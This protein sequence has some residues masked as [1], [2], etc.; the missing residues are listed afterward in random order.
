LSV[1]SDGLDIQNVANA[2]SMGQLAE[3]KRESH[4]LD[5]LRAGERV[6][7]PIRMRPRNFEVKQTFSFDQRFSYHTLGAYRVIWEAGVINICLGG[8]DPEKKV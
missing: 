5:L 4:E 7:H 6:R 8:R 1:V 3:P 2:D